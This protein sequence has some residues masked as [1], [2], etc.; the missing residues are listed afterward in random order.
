MPREETPL[1]QMLNQ[2]VITLQDRRFP[3][4]YEDGY[5]QFQ[6]I[7]RYSTL[8]DWS[9]YERLMEIVKVQQSGRWT[10]GYLTGWFAALFD[11]L[12]EG[13]FTWA[14]AHVQQ[15]TACDT[16]SEQQPQGEEQHV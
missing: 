14:K 1:V 8:S 4:G 2:K 16:T 9:I 11:T 15:L 7:D 10:A 13:R 6:L 5:Q 12:P 3:H